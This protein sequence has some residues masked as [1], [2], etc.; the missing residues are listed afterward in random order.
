MI[1][2]KIK[3]IDLN[4]NEECK[5]KWSHGVPGFADGSPVL[6]VSATRPDK[7]NISHQFKVLRYF[8][9]EFSTMYIMHSKKLTQYCQLK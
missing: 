8:I 6:C 9:C 1:C 2:L 3:Y 7:H 5:S 4:I